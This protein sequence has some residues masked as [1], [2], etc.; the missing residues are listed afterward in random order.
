MQLMAYISSFVLSCS[1]LIS[2]SPKI[3]AV[4]I[5]LTCTPK[6]G[7]TSAKFSLWAE[8]YTRTRPAVNDGLLPYNAE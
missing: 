8:E 1:H 2:Y 7:H 4:V 5:H 6:Q 3:D